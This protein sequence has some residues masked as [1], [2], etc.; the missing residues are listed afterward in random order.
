MFAS[1]EWIFEKKKTGQKRRIISSL[2]FH[3]LKLHFKCIVTLNAM[4]KSKLRYLIPFSKLINHDKKKKSVGERFKIFKIWLHHRVRRLK[5]SVTHHRENYI[6]GK[7][8]NSSTQLLEWSDSAH[9]PIAFR[10]LRRICCANSSFSFQF[11]RESSSG[12]TYILVHMICGVFWQKIR[13]AL[14]FGVL[15]ILA[16]G[17]QFRFLRK[18]AISIENISNVSSWSK[19]HFLTVI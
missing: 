2:L 3:F 13:D 1:H 16:R 19:L 4:V 5:W 6:F 7:F 11:W 14:K 15:K 9:L 8:L 10:F 17:Q 12:V 18:F